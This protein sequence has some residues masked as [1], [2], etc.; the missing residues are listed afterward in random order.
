[1][2]EAGFVVL[3]VAVLHWF[4]TSIPRAAMTCGDSLASARALRLRFIVAAVAWIA[5]TMGLAYAGVLARW[6]RR[7]PPLM[8]VFL[9]IFVLG[10]VLAR[11]AIGD[12][13]ARG[14]PLAALVGLQSF[15]FPLEVVM[16]AAYER[17]LMPIQMS[18]SG[19]NFDVL[20]GITAVILAA[21]L[22][23]GHPPRA[24]VWAWNVMGVLLLANIVTVAV[25]SVPTFARFGS[26]PDRLN[27]FVADPPFV[28]LP[29][30]LV[31]TAWAGHLVV[32]RA[33]SLRR[34]SAP[35]PR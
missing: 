20:T 29:T 21:W 34:P 13:L 19:R 28:L 12:R 8:G 11:S 17:G 1:M 24:V 30:V 25:L 16:H 23:F 7:P 14:L 33:L 35:D 27:T 18:Y 32:F 26:T 6:E 22:R 4:Y 2:L 10:I 5:M 3:A 31:L 9:G 15:R